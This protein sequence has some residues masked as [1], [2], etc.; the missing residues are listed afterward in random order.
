M[1]QHVPLL[2]VKF[3]VVA[4]LRKTDAYFLLHL[5]EEKISKISQMK[6]KFRNT[7]KSEKKK[8]KI[9]SLRF[10]IFFFFFLVYHT[11]PTEVASG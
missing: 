3:W 9:S 2:C 11:Q 10:F 4:L 8:E 1:L 5:S 7:K 6:K